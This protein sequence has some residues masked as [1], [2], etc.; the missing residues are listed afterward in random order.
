MR[1]VSDV[2]RD[3][4]KLVL[5]CTSMVCA[6]Q[7]LASTRH[8]GTQECLGPASVTAV[9]NAQGCCIWGNGG[10]HMSLVSVVVTY[11]T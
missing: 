9:S 1:F 11:I 7:K 6:E 4:A 10:I 2:E 5:V 3:L 8:H